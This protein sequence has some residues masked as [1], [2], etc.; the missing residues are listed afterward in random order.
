[1]AE[2]RRPAAATPA[3]RK[4]YSRLGAGRRIPSEYEL[5]S[6]DLH[7]NYPRRFELGGD[8]PVIEWYYRYRE[9]SAL[10]A[11]DWERFSDPRRTTYREY[12]VLQDR[13]EDVIDGLL[14]EI[15]ESEYDEHLSE[16]WVTFLDR[17][18]GPLRYPCHGLQML[19][20]YI[21]QL[22]PASRVTNCGA[23]QAADELRR[24]QR[25]AYRTA[26]L[27]AHR[28]GMKPDAHRQR[29]EQAAPFQ[30]LRRLVELALVTY[31]WGESLI[32]TNLVIKPMVDRLVNKELA[33]ALA[34][35]NDDPMLRGIHFSLDEDARW[36]R[37]WTAELVRI[38]V[39]DTPANGATIRGWIDAWSPLA[40]AA[41]AGLAAVTSMA[42]VALDPEAVMARILQGVAEDRSAMLGVAG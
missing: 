29:W 11:R 42:P 6:S 4:T 3:P 15:D 14:R 24:V 23:F 35:A 26:Q 18:Y 40:E 34:D 10:S 5:V 17:W 39:E 16:E 32:V 1:M 41:V 9:G 12:N 22:A 36:H 8:N 31:D 19:A 38:A 27:A 30:T 2:K 20:A 21:A 13:K 28:P 25:I 7:Y 33:G 37:Q